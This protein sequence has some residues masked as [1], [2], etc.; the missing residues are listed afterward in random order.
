MQEPKVKKTKLKRVLT[1]ADITNQK[2]QRIPFE[3]EFLEV[4]GQPQ[5]RGVWFVYGTSGSGKST[6]IMQLAKEFSKYYKTLYDPL[7]EETDDSDFIE[8]V[9]LVNMQ[10]VGSNFHAQQ[11]D[12]D[13]LNIYLEKRGSP[14]VVIIDSATYFFKNWNEYLA[15]KNKWQTKKI[16]I[17]I[18][19]AEGKNPRTELEK[20]IKYNAKMKVFVSGYLAINQGRTF[21]TKNTFI[22]WPEGYDKLRG[23]DAHKE[24]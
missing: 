23:Q 24:N 21:G 16:I 2:V 8:R 1:V 15:F 22:T 20:S 11:Y 19:H 4:F 3:D 14:K 5:N 6:F 9:A 17:V 10:D 7:E 13:E 12:L 18:G